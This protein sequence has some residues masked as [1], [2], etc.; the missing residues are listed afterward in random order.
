MLRVLPAPDLLADWI[1]RAVQCSL[2]WIL[3]E[4]DV[5]THSGNVLKCAVTHLAER[6]ALSGKTDIVQPELSA[7]LTG[8]LSV[9]ITR[10]SINILTS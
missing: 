10:C 1:C 6:R 4:T 3:S 2:M 7:D 8:H 9:T 5:A